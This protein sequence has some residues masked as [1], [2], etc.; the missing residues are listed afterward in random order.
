VPTPVIPVYEPDTRAVGTVPA[1]RIEAFSAV[2]LRFTAAEP[3]KD[4]AAAVAPLEISKLRAFCRTVA[5]DAV[6]VKAAVIVLAAKL[7]LPSLATI[8]E[9]PFVLEAEVRALSIVPVVMAVAF[10]LVRFAPEPDTAPLNVV[11]VITLAAK[12]PLPSL[13]TIVLAPLAEAADVRALSKVPVVIAVA[14]NDVI[15]APEPVNVVAV[16]PA[17]AKLPEPSRATIVL[18][19]FVADA[20]VRAFNSVPVVMFDALVVSV[21]AE[22]AK[23]DTLDA[24]IAIPTLEALV[25]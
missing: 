12:L 20:D 1:S 8:V 19:P 25:I 10:K 24:V 3:L 16:I 18:A 4:T 15:E 5:L 2:T 17:A 23:P 21:V 7:P 6:P 11:A 22:A 9:A 13:A 14:F